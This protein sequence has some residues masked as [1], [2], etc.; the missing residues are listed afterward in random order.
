MDSE[1]V[2]AP[3]AELKKA[4]A[5]PLAKCRAAAA[6]HDC[7]TAKACVKQAGRVDV[8]DDAALKSCL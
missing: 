5:D 2:E 7:A 1:Q 4:A 3:K 8:G 6:R